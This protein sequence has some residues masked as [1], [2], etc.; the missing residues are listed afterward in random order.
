LLFEQI[1]AAEKYMVTIKD[2]GHMMIGEK[3]PVE[4]MK[5]F[6]NAFFGYYLQGREEYREYFSEEFVDQVEE[7]AWGIYQNKNGEALWID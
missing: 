1:G 5:H 3:R 7:L 6:V 2:K 4:I